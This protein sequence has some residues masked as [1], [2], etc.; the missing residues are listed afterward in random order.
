MD[1]TYGLDHSV[2]S[3]PQGDDLDTTFAE[4]SG[5]EVLLQD[6]FKQV[7]TPAGSCFW[8]PTRTLDLRDYLRDSLSTTDVA[9]LEKALE[10]LFEE[11][12]RTL[13]EA[14]VSYDGNLRTLTITLTITPVRGVTFQAI[15]TADSNAIRIERV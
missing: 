4:I 12:P 3:G 2:L 1:A 8:A 15:L 6:V 9:A 10:Q 11:D 13:V 14:S 5:E 7:T